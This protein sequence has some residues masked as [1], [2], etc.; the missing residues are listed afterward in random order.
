[1]NLPLLIPCIAAFVLGPAIAPDLEL[2]VAGILTTQAIPQ[3][4]APHGELPSVSDMDVPGVCTLDSLRQV[5]GVEDHDA[6]AEEKTKARA[7]RKRR[8]DA[9]E[10][11]GMLM[12]LLHILQDAK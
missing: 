11:F 12:L 6:I 4:R 10:R 3:E 5:D 9:D 8:T 7:E 1:M 2:G